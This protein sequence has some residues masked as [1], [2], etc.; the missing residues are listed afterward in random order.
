M[1]EALEQLRQ[2]AARQVRE[3][4]D[5]RVEMIEQGWHYAYENLEIELPRRDV[6]RIVDEELL[7]HY[8]RQEMWTELTDYDKLDAAFASMEARGL[9]A[10]QNFTCCNTCGRAEIWD[11]IASAEES[12]EV[13]GYAFYH[14][15]DT[16]G[17]EEG[18]TIYIKYG[19]TTG[20]TA[21]E[22]G[23]HICDAFEESGLIVG[24]SGSADDAIEVDVAD[25]RKRRANELPLAVEQD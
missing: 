9:V 2:W 8:G 1:N 3:G 17:V 25:W 13:I 10:R 20:T 23:N 14:M 16:E 12:R 18:G 19:P 11:E 15:Q 5:S 21:E 7:A 4:F 6:S 22:V 24:W